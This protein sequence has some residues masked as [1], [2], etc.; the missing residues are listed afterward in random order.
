LKILFAKQ[1]SLACVLA[2]ATTLAGAQQTTPTPE[3]PAPQH[4]GTVV[5]SR[6][7]DDPAA[8]KTAPENKSSVI[9]QVTDADRNALTFTRYSL[10]VHLHP[11]DHGI[12]VR[13][14]LDV[15]NDSD[16]ALKQLPLQLSSTLEWEQIRLVGTPSSELKFVATPIASDADHTGLLNEAAVQLPEP[17]APAATLHLDL[18]YSGTIAQDAKR[19]EQIGTPPKVAQSSDWDQISPDFIGLRGFGNVVW[20]PVASIPAR[21]GDGDKLFAEV[22]ETK[23][24]QQKAIV[25][26]A[27]TA[28]VSGS[29][30][31]IAI[32][33]GTVEP[34]QFTPGDADNHIPGI[35]RTQLAAGPLLF[36]TLSLF[37]ANRQKLSGNS[38]DAYAR[39]G[40]EGTVQSYI[41]AAALVS[42]LLRSWLGDTPKSP[43][44]IFDLS[45]PSDAP[46]EERQTLFT[47]LQTMAPEQLAA[48][49]SHSLAHAFFQSP[50]PWLNEGVAHFMASLWTEQTHDRDTAL[51]QLDEQRGALALVEPGEDAANGAAPHAQGAGLIAN[52]NAIFYRTKATYVLWM[53]R[54]LIGD[55]ALQNALKLYDPAKDTNDS[56]FEDLL[57]K[58]SVA[59]PGHEELHQFFEDW[60]YHDPG[61][62]DLSIAG[63]YPSV[64]NVPGTYIIAVDVMN[65]GNA[66]ADIPVTVSSTNTQ[67]TERLFIPAHDHAVRRLL[68]QG[69]PTQVQVNDGVVPETTASVHVEQIHYT[70]PI[71]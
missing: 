71:K 6:S 30:P 39:P 64:A 2:F 47:G 46:F 63:T 25:D 34:I 31:N 9:S 19:L 41:A 16:H 17:L 48:P 27:L 42:P 44:S 33:N 65:Y 54:S 26:I 7:D 38:I 61:L 50:R 62:P 24:R 21:L 57:T 29:A 43:L 35:A 28:E 32:L 15:R 3:S 69:E 51:A 56:Y 23:Q 45:S 10:D 59:Q 20:Y 22:G 12:A 68:I 52:P 66:C 67:V 11:A 49:M 5:F 14:Q 1:C 13:A 37:I 60:V 55:T 36:Q 53:L 70:Q 18:V 58:T 40:D 4:H 8:P